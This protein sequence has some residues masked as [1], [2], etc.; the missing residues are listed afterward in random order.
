MGRLT[1]ASGAGGGEREREMQEGGWVAVAVAARQPVQEPALVTTALPA[2]GSAAAF[3]VVH[4]AQVGAPLKRLGNT[5]LLGDPAARIK[6]LAE[7]IA[8]AAG[9]EA[10]RLNGRAA[11]GHRAAEEGTGRTIRAP[12]R[13][14]AVIGEGTE[15]SNAEQPAQANRTQLHDWAPAQR[16]GLLAGMAEQA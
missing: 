11:K 14:A 6:I 8:R 4:G 1:P 16:G 12:T 15:L 10:D 5:G 2:V 7:G 3:F 9:I 13:E